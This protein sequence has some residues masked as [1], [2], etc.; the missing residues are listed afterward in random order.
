V[1]FVEVWA[2]CPVCRAGR[3]FVVCQWRFG[4]SG[5]PVCF[6]VFSPMSAIYC[7][8]LYLINGH[9]GGATHAKT[10]LSAV[11]VLRQAARSCTNTPFVCMLV[12]KYN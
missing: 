4:L 11:S 2:V 5:N 1:R 6:Q 9:S 10:M 3:R 7:S 8:T 12:K